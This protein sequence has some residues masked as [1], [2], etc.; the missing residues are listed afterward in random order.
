[1]TL[2]FIKHDYQR[3]VHSPVPTPATIGCPERRDDAIF[4]FTPLRSQYSAALPTARPNDSNP[5]QET[6]VVPRCLV[7]LPE[8]DTLMGKTLDRRSYSFHRRS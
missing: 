2:P 6:P 5:T 1:M 3:V 4:W 7:V 8:L